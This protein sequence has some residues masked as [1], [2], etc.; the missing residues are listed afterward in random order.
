M[1]KFAKILAAILVPVF[2][3]TSC[4]DDNDTPQLETFMCI[5]TLES[6]TE[7]ATTFTTREDGDSPLVTFTSTRTFEKDQV[8]VGNR[9]LLAYSNASGKRM[10]SGLINLLGLYKIFNGNIQ[11]ASLEEIEKLRKSPISVNELQRSGTY[12]NLF[13]SAP[14]IADPK[15]YNLYVDEATI[16]TPTPDVY[17]GFVSDTQTATQEKSFYGSFSISNVWSRPSC[18]GIN[19]HYSAN[20]QNKVQ[21]FVKD[22]YDIRPVE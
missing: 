1:N 13:T 10:E 20:G 21:T 3:L 16:D 17:I 7:K 12:I 14:V 15:T 18:K 5:A 6:A 19:F 9:Y 11:T 22:G 8:I 4:N 2:A